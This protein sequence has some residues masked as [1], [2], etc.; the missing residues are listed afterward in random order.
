MIISGEKWACEACV[1][2]HRV[3]NCQHAGECYF[4]FVFRCSPSPPPKYLPAS[5]AARHAMQT[6]SF[7][8]PG[9]SPVTTHTH[10]HTQSL[11]LSLRR[12]SCLASRLLFG[13]WLE[14]EWV[15]TAR[16]ALDNH[17]VVTSS[18][19]EVAYTPTLP[20]APIADVA[21]SPHFDPPNPP[22]WHRENGLLLPPRRQAN[23]AVVATADR[24]LVHIKPKG[25]PTTQCNHCRSMRKSRSSHVRCDCGE[26]WHKCIHLL[27]PVE[28]HRGKCS[29]LLRHASRAMPRPTPL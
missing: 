14:A 13:L 26:K 20:P 24:P 22:V 2:G 4:P 9:R 25:R 8:S 21:V 12:Y 7:A 6:T 19:S 10:T 27:A 29:P 16:S 17:Q 18:T 5:P 1:R 11:S 28:G 23:S 3:S 15:G